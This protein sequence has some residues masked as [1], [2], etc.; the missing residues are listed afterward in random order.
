MALRIFGL[1]VLAGL[2]MA[3]F[4][5]GMSFVISMDATHLHAGMF[6]AVLAFAVIGAFYSVR[7]FIRVSQG[8]HD[9]LG[10]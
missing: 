2:A 10:K 3:L 4:A 9:L 5:F 8:H 6:A 7:Y 1:F